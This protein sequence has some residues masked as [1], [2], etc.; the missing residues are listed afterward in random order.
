MVTINCKDGGWQ[1][2]MSLLVKLRDG[3]MLMLWDGVFL[4]LKRER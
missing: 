3:E 1:P 4:V 2:P